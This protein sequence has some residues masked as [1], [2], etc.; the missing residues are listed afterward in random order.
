MSACPQDPYS[1]APRP[2]RQIPAWARVLLVVALYF[3]LATVLSVPMVV[4]LVLSAL[5]EWG[6]GAPP[7]L[8]PDDFSRL[9]QLTSGMGLLWGG[10][11]LGAAAGA[12]AIMWLAWKGVPPLRWG[13]LPRPGLGREV[14][15]GLALGPTLFGL[16]SVAM[17]ALGWATF[18]PGSLPAHGIVL[19]VVAFAMAAL[20]EE[21][22]VRGYIL[23]VLEDAHGVR[24]AVLVSSGLFG[25]LHA[26]NPNVTLL[27]LPN[28][29]ATGLVLAQAYYVTR[30]LWL[31]WA[32]H[33]SWNFTQMVVFGLPVS[34]LAGEGILSPM[35]TGPSW[36]TG[37]DFGPEGG[38]AC[39]LALAVASF[40]LWSYGRAFPPTWPPQRQEDQVPPPR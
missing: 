10:A 18:Q 37:G 14:V 30:R 11:S 31:V 28:L 5:R 2:P 6:P 12:V 7:D 40:L 3:G 1:S 22:L 34:G 26:V 17:M 36:G 9:I 21:W 33:F 39:L 25:L 24:A 19:A 35:V 32:F 13:L 23:Q 15:F 8:S 27:S 38:V 20:A 16:V 29:I 4:V